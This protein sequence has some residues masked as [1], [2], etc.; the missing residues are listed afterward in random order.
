MYDQ[1]YPPVDPNNG[2]IAVTMR[3]HWLAFL[4]G[5]F[6]PYLGINGHRVKAGW[7]R[8]VIPM[9]PGQ[10]HVHAHVPYLIPPRIGPADTVVPVYAGQVVEVEYRAPMIAWLGGTIGP[11]PQRFRGQA[12]AVALMTVPLAVLLCVVGL[13]GVFSLDS[14]T[15]REGTALPPQPSLPAL[16]DLSS[17][18]PPDLSPSGAATSAAAKPTLKSVPA[19]TLVG[20]SWTASDKTYTMAISGV[21]FAFR[22]PPTWGCLPGKIDI[23]GAKAWVCIDEGNPFDASAPEPD[24]TKRLQFMLRPCPNSCGTADVLALDKDWFDKGA[25]IVNRGVGTSYVEVARNAD[26]R[27]VLDMSHYITDAAGKKW[28]VAVGTYSRPETKSPVQ[29]IVNDILTQAG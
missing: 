19:R 10:H 25:Q 9:P 26:G 18:A 6:Q 28:Q 21:P 4:I 20:P 2:A 17:L 29:K 16:P 27:Y 24:R 23:E 1:Q 14:P 15:E 3:Y 5:L 8:T 12:A 22:T 13:L 7:G 11:P